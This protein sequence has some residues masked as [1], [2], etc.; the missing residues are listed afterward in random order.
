MTVSLLCVADHDL[1]GQILWP[2]ASLLAKYLAANE[3]VLQGCN[4]ACEL[5]A[6]L[7]LVGLVAAQ[8]C[9]V[10]LTDHNSV[11]LRVLAKNAAL[12]QA[13][14]NIRYYKSVSVHK[15][16]IPMAT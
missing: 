6:G 10:V 13:K 7:G 12:N 1:T 9:P 3:A 11:V 16:L 2:A 8:T 15:Q 5:G 14:H 4:C